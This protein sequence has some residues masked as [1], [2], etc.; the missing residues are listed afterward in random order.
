MA[1]EREP[2]PR[3]RI[4]GQGRAKGRTRSTERRTP[5]GSRP[6][7]TSPFRLPRSAGLFVRKVAV[8]GVKTLLQHGGFS[9][10]QVLAADPAEQI[11]LRRIRQRGELADLQLDGVGEG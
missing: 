7:P 10:G 9:G 2:A 8:A 11:P 6:I 3:P 5:R 4:A 1:E